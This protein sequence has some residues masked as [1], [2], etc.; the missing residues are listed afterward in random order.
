M[1]AYIISCIVLSLIILAFIPAMIAAHKDYPFFRWYIYGL[2]LFPVATVHGLLIKRPTCII[3][4]YK[5]LDERS[6]S[7]KSYRVVPVKKIKRKFSAGYIC[8]VLSAKLL[9]S[10][11]V[12]IAVYAIMRTYISD[13]G[14]LLFTGIVFWIL[15]AICMMV[16]ELSGYSRIPLIADEVTKRTLIILVFSVMVSFVLYFLKVFI[17][18][19]ISQHREFVRFICTAVAFIVQVVLIFLMQ[20]RYY[21]AFARFFDYCILTVYAYV[22][23]ASITLVFLSLTDVFHFAFSILSMPMQLFNFSYF[24]DIVYI[25]KLPTIYSV[26]LVHIFVVVLLLISGWQCHRYKKKERE[27]RVEYRTKAFRMSRK[28]ALRRHIPKTGFP[29]VKPIK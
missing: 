4:I 5:S 27:A 25:E 2:I 26:A 29:M 21:G 13:I 28:R 22:M 9:F 16:V 7:R 14:L 17:T 10:L 3:N 18:S 1:P 6:R 24:S 11:F 20:R 15:L 12:A 23:F 19:N 8:A